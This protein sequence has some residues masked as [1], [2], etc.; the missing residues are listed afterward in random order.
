[1][2]PPSTSQSVSQN[3][4]LCRMGVYICPPKNLLGTTM[5]FEA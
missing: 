4:R 2:S 1:M 3:H 5:D